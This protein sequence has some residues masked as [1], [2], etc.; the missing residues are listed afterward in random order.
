MMR[1][2]RR[3]EA[4]AAGAAGAAGAESDRR[5]EVAHREWVEREFDNQTVVAVYIGA[6]C[7]CSPGR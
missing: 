1:A 4:P 5:E 3:D 2:D 7:A 6:T